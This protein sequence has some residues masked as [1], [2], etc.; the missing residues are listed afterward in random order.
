MEE[1]D[2]QGMMIQ[3]LREIREELCSNNSRVEQG[4]AKIEQL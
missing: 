3:L 1:Q 4:N 2:T